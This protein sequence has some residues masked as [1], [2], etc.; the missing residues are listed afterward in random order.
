MRLSLGA[1]PRQFLLLAC[2]A[3]G[4]LW[5][6]KPCLG[7][8]TKTIDCPEGRDYHD[9]RQ[10]AGR[11]EYCELD[12]PGSLHVRDGASRFWYSAGHFGEG[13]TYD[14]GRKVG[15]WRECNRFDHCR[16][17]TYELEY[18]NEK[19]RGTRSEVPV[20]FEGGKYIFDFNSCR[21]TWVTRRSADS[22]L[23]LNIVSGLIRCQIT[24]IPSTEKDRPAGEHGSYLCEIP[25]AV[26]VRKFD[27]LD[28][29]KELP[30]AGL[31]QFCRPD[32]PGLTAS[33]GPAAQAVAI[34]GNTAFIDAVS[35][36][37]THGWT[38]LANA[39]DVECAALGRLGKG[40][41]RLTLRLNRYAEGLVLD[42]MGKEE[43]K[44]DACAGR[45]P[46]SPMETLRDASGR[47]L[48]LLRLSRDPTT[49]QR[50]RSCITSQI[51]FQPTC[52]SQ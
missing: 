45:V 11:D 38:T 49:A 39:N 27:S 41:E 2:A 35:K 28:L 47:T 17:L 18:P 9:D 8:W 24:Y 20:R 10:Y 37:E 22:F 31:P 36:K 50:Q 25:Y 44:A 12:L 7:Q 29:R 5:A 48:F 42:R 30:K 15:R 16:D 51:K 14:K 3:W 6:P 21:S 4:G 23:E 32:E 40:S 46:F 1:T 52:A 43:I 26:G 19:T 33:G 34:W 13:G